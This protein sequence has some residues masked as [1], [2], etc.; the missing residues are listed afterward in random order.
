MLRR[1][2]ALAQAAAVA[3]AAKTAKPS[4]GAKGEKQVREREKAGGTGKHQRNVSSPPRQEAAKSAPQLPPLLGYP[5]RRAAAAE[6]LY[7]GVR[8]NY[9]NQKPFALHYTHSEDLPSPS[10]ERERHDLQLEMQLPRD[11]QMGYDNIS[12]NIQRQLGYSGE[13][14]EADAAEH[15]GGQGGRHGPPREGFHMS[16]YFGNLF[17][18]ERHHNSSLPYSAYDTNNVLG[19]R[20]F[21]LNMHVRH[22]A[23]GVRIRTEDLLHRMR[24]YQACAA[25][26]LPL[27]S[28]LPLHVRAR[29]NALAEE[30]SGRK[31]TL[32][33]GSINHRTLFSAHGRD[34]PTPSDEQARRRHL[35]GGPSHP[36]PQDLSI[37]TR[38]QDTAGGEEAT[39]QSDIRATALQYFSDAS[40]APPV[41]QTD[42]SAPSMRTSTVSRRHPQ[43]WMPLQMLKPMGHSWSASVRSS[44]VR[45]PSMQLMQE[46]LD[47]KG[48]GWKRK[49]RSLWQQDVDTAGFRPH[50]YF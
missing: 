1:S 42:G 30:Q 13:A 2:V 33:S 20:L 28:P 11:G 21:P 24:D 5:L 6:M 3:S 8:T 26:G 35:R 37:L 50:R 15:G 49:S 46:R 19:L 23:E 43:Y 29:L 34:E 16:N 14:E 39:A 32:Y 9:L 18:P 17:H 40:H 36:R 48:F 7:G 10:L 47:Q 45:G 12:M 38:P 27:Q 31:E 44:G 22:R 4:G 25:H 41:M